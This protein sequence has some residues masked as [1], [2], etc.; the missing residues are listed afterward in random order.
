M[1]MVLMVHVE[2]P[3][4]EGENKNKLHNHVVI[5]DSHLL[6]YVLTYGR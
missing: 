3:G 5:A 6:T 2:G 4:Y 1:M